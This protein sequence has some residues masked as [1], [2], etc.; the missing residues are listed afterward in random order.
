[1]P[2]KKKEESLNAHVWRNRGVLPE[3]YEACD[4]AL[5]LMVEAIKRS[6]GLEHAV[7]EEAIFQYYA[8]PNRTEEFQKKHR[9]K[10]PAP[11]SGVCVWEFRGEYAAPKKA[12]KKK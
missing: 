6:K 12:K 8:L 11:K 9:W 2:K 5:P 3:A 4:Q 10:P 1:M 7:Y